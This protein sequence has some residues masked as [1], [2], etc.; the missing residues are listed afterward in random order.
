MRRRRSHARRRHDRR[1]LKSVPAML[2]AAR[3]TETGSSR[4]RRRRVPNPETPLTQGPPDGDP[5]ADPE[6]PYKAH[7]LA[8]SRKFSEPIINHAKT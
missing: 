4:W 3:P 5:Y 8:S 7:R 6:A 2:C 1:Q